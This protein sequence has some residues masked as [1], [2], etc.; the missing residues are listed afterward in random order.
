MGR[1]KNSMEIKM[2]KGA[3]YIKK[4]ERDEAIFPPD[5]RALLWCYSGSEQRVRRANKRKFIEVLAMG[6]RVRSIPFRHIQMVEVPIGVP[7][8]NFLHIPIL[9]ISRGGTAT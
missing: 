7:M 9:Y 8:P 1:A 6:F 4:G 5:L 2:A 3:H